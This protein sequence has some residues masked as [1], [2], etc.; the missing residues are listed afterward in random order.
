MLA[1]VRRVPPRATWWCE[2]DGERVEHDWR[3][4][5]CPRCLAKRPPV[6][7]MKGVSLEEQLASRR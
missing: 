4:E 1:A 7:G 3:E 6:P 5:Y 2:H